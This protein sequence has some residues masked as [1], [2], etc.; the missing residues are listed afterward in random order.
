LGYG[1]TA[2]MMGG[3]MPKENLLIVL[4]FPEDTSI[5]DKIRHDFP[6]I[7]VK[8]HQLKRPNFSFDA[9]EGFPKGCFLLY[10]FDS[11][12]LLFHFFTSLSISE[13]SMRRRASMRDGLILV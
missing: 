4:P 7:H 11:S 5:T 1:I 3:G 12:I 13:P 8:Y 9:D 10:P 6:Y 2:G